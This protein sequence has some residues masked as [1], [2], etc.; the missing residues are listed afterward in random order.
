MASHQATQGASVSSNRLGP[1]RRSMLGRLGQRYMRWRYRGIVGARDVAPV[2]VYEHHRLIAIGY[3]L[4]EWFVSRANKVDARLKLLAMTKAAA[5]VNCEWCMDFASAVALHEGLTKRQLREL[6]RYRDS[7]AFSA[8]ERLVLDYT[9]AITRTPSAV[10]DA[11]I[12]RMRQHFTDP[13]VV[14]LAASIVLENV[15]ARMNC[16]V[17]V[18][19]QGFTAGG[20]CVVGER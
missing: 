13:Q 9:T 11:L 3:D 1:A 18:R 2:D 16:A 20:A 14:E 4:F 19:P 8:V 6:A 5:A 12:D 7:D 10:D 15:H 17:G